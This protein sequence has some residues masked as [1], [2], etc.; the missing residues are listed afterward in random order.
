[1]D[2]LNVLHICDYAAAYRG[3]FIDSLE[4]LEKHRGNIKNFYLFPARARQAPAEEWIKELNSD[5]EVAYLQ[6]RNLL[7]NIRLF[8]KIIRTHKIDRIVRHFTDFK[9]DIIIKAFFDGRKVVRFFHCD[10]TRSANPFKHRLKEFV[11]KRNR[12]VGVSDAIANKI[13][14]VHPSFEVHAIVNAIRF[15][16]LDKVDEFRRE[17]CVALLMMGWD[18]ERKGV[19]LAVRAVHTLRKKHDVILQIIGGRNEDKIKELAK[20]ILGEEADWIRYLPP[21]NNVGTYY[22]ASDIFL[23]PSRQEAFGYANIE[24]AY[25]KNSIVLSR[26][27]GQGQLN[28]EG[29]YWVEPNNAEQL[30]QQ[31]ET[32]IIELKLPEKIKQKERVSEQVKQA[33]SLEEWADKLAA[34]L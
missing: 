13:R 12:L 18:Y 28:I 8:L 3:N 10:C 4:A 16:R 32:A 9:I 11:W 34:V 22:R 23:S 2:T 33:Y 7:K 31:L 24:A 14:A 15:D 26:V 25:C 1:M 20:N 21:T 6:E 17:S 5:N 30:A 19:D 27:D 29:A